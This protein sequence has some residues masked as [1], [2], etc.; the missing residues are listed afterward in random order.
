MSGNS[1]GIGMIGLGG[2]FRH[3]LKLVNELEYV[4]IEAL[5]D[6]NEEQMRIVAEELG[7][8]ED[9]L[10]TNY[11]AI[12]RDP[13]VHAVIS[14]VPNRY[15]AEILRL[16]IAHGKPVMSEKP[17][18][19]NYEEAKELKDLYD[20]HPIP[21]MVGFSYRYVPSF[22]LAKQLLADG[23]LGPIQHIFVQ[24]LQEWGAAPFK[25]PYSWRF[26]QTESGTGALGDLGS[27]MIDCARY[28]VG[29]FTSIS[30]QLS[31]MVEK[32]KLSKTDDTLIQVDVDDFSSFQADLEGGVKGVF[33]TSRNA[34]GCG[35]Q[36]EVTLYGEQGA[37]RVCCE[38]P[39][40]LD[41]WSIVPGEERAVH[42]TLQVPSKFRRNQL[43]DFLDLLHWRE[44]PG[45]PSF[46]DGYENQRVLDA[47]IRSS[48]TR[49]WIE[50]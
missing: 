20:L 12:I 7:I 28:L 36:L 40:Q 16:C 3:H 37:I 4:E 24:Y 21:C 23:R 17:F 46:K 14:I 32:R 27:H 22:R 10:Y 29:E 30:G 8:N 49:A 42:E 31:T 11:E 13:K 43:D 44:V 26:S 19:R 35:N 50:L 25:T 38:R 39:E 5:C 6:V 33:Q 47:I 2:M 1:M 15:H 48:A 34:I 45:A 41:Y 18:T 9:K